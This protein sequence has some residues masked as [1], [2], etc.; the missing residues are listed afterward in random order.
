M[1]PLEVSRFKPS[2]VWSETVMIET[3][4]PFESVFLMAWV[5]PGVVVAEGRVIVTSPDARRMSSL[6]VSA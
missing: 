2:M 1:P 4:V 5:R 6:S 3:V